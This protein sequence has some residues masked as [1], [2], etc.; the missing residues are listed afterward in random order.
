MKLT[1]QDQALAER[2]APGVLSR[3]G[4]LGRDHRP[5]SE[6]VATDAT[7]VEALGVTHA[8]IAAALAEA[9]D[10]AIEAFGA[11]AEVRGL[12]A[13]CIEA[14]GR[15]VCPWGGCGGFDKGEIVLTGPDG[16]T[17]AFTPLSVHL[18]ARHGFY[19]GRGS[20]YRIEP[21]KACRMLGLGGEKGG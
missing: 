7:A 13:T 18:I 9:R 12:K 19:Q 21:G 10:T 11:P 5:V 15:I 4:F 1:P 17:L 6:I 2:M 16:E 3:D 8:E 20:R 14:R